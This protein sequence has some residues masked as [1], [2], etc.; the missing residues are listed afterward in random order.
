MPPSPSPDT[1]PPA[2]PSATVRRRVARRRIGWLVV[3]TGL[4]VL[5]WYGL[6]HVSVWRA[7]AALERRDTLWAG[8][9]ST[10]ARGVG[11]G[12]ADGQLVFAQAERRAGRLAEA[13]QAL[14][15][16]ARAGAEAKLVER[17]RR[18]LV[19]QAGQVEALGP[20]WDELFATAG[21]DGPEVSKA[22]VLAAL[23]R[24]GLASAKQ[25]L[26]AWSRDF[27]DDA[28]PW[29]LL[30][31][32]QAT[33]RHWPEALVAFEAAIDRDATRADAF[34]ERGKVFARLGRLPEARQALEQAH[35]RKPLSRV[36]ALELGQ[37]LV[38]L[39]EV[40]AARRWYSES[41][42][43]LGDEPALLSGLGD[44]EL[45]TGRMTEATALLKRAVAACPEDAQTHYLLARALAAT[46]HPEEA[47]GHFEIMRTA[48]EPLKQ[49]NRMIRT[50][51]EGGDSADLRC[52]IGRLVW[53]YKSRREGLDWIRAALVLDR[54]HATAN[55]LRAEY[56]ATLA[57]PSGPQGAP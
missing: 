13:K 32:V 41:I 42:A 8:R 28:E 38:K 40:D 37:C 35:H 44:L 3:A 47:A 14:D 23:A 29:F 16:A 26:A 19:A 30:G 56:E 21:S 51:E 49:I 45:Q 46:G 12:A 33:G 25:V 7:E 48:Q 2:V 17:E 15:A 31:R 52:E 50:A 6:Y 36:G 11:C 57:A 27:P 43:R 10:L 53:Q 24:G 9:W 20:Y 34:E 22:Y 18:L 39:G 1:F 54:G 4:A 5:A 55:R